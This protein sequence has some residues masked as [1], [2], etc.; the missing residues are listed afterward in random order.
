MPN[1][2]VIISTFNRP[3]LLRQAIESVCSQSFQDW[4]LIVINNGSTDDT[5]QVIS[6]YVQK[7]SRISSVFQKRSILSRVRALGSRLAKGEYVTY[8]DDDDYYFPNKLDVQVEFLDKHK[9]IALV[10]S[11][12]D[13]VD[14]NQKII[15]VLPEKPA[16]NYLELIHGN[17]IQLSSALF[18]RKCFNQIG[19]FNTS[20]DSCDDYEFCLRLTKN[21]PI[22]FLP[23]NV[24]IYRW[25]SQNMS[26]KKVLRIKN[27]INIYKQIW[28]ESLIQE[29]RTAI[30]RRVLELTYWRA[31]D[32]F[33]SGHYSD[34]CLYFFM[35]IYFDPFIGLSVPWGRFSNSI[36]QFFK[37]YWAFVYSALKLIFVRRS[38]V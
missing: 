17:A 33:A 26:H 20:L 24:G 29:E 3:S 10:Y 8:L 35:A 5:A 11:Y 32:A 16:A 15:R 4:E 19:S 1:V 23:V 9:D 21:F 25:H 27:E 22:A 14:E 13:L 6:E 37:P 28:K 18:R 31:S 12:L 36:F 7:D 38:N 34:A 30:L 2:S